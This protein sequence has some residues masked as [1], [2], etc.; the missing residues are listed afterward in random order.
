M[1]YSTNKFRIPAVFGLCGIGKL[2]CMGSK[3]KSLAETATGTPRR[4][5]G[6]LISVAPSVLLTSIWIV[7]R[8]R[9][10]PLMRMCPLP[11]S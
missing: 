5:I 10:S 2:V 1:S 6:M 11:A 9:K 8:N 7:Q 4:R 3:V